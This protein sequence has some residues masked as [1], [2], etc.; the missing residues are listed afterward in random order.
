VTAAA[1]AA[2][3]FVV[4]ATLDGPDLEDLGIAGLTLLV[5][6]PVAIAIAGAVLKFRPGLRDVEVGF[7]AAAGVYG[8]FSLLGLIVYVAVHAFPQGLR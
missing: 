3:T 1:F 4:F 8:V 5:Q 7:I 6:A 2:F